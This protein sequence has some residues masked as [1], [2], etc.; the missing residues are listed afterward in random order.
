VA[1][2]N[3][4]SFFANTSLERR[5]EV[6]K[7][8]H[9]AVLLISL[10]LSVTSALGRELESLK[11]GAEVQNKFQPGTTYQVQEVT[12]RG[13][14]VVIP[15]KGGMKGALSGGKSPLGTTRVFLE[16]DEI[17][18]VRP[19]APLTPED[20]NGEDGFRRLQEVL[21]DD[22]S[23]ID[24]AVDK[25]AKE[26]TEQLRDR[27]ALLRGVL[28]KTKDAGLRKFLEK[29]L[30]E[31]AQAHGYLRRALET[32]LW[33]QGKKDAVEATE[34]AWDL[35]LHALLDKG[36]H[37]KPDREALR[38][39]RGALENKV[40]DELDRRLGQDREGATADAKRLLETFGGRARNNHLELPEDMKRFL[41]DL[42]AVSEIGSDVVSA[43]PGPPGLQ[44]PA[45]QLGP[46][47]PPLSKAPALGDL[48]LELPS[49]EPGLKRPELPALPG[50]EDGPQAPN[51]FERDGP[52]DQETVAQIDTIFEDALK[53]EPENLQAELLEVEAE[54]LQQGPAEN[55]ELDPALIRVRTMLRD[56]N[57]HLQR[58]A[59][60]ALESDPVA[61]AAELYRRG[62][63]YER[64]LRQL[65]GNLRDGYR[66]ALA[67][68]GGL[69]KRAREAA[70]GKAKP[71]TPFEGA[72]Q[73]R[74]LR[75]KQAEAIAQGLNGLAKQLQLEEAEISRRIK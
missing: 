52:A 75:I 14:W 60:E 53:A 70:R 26:V 17:A 57:R 23:A 11:P 10:V 16:R 2:A 55:A 7:I 41:K 47:I 38:N 39:V 1:S 5:S 21:R 4:S 64:A 13:A 36:P 6:M 19:L 54:L 44:V 58:I 46:E 63:A 12:P 71:L 62:A 30:A 18:G 66:G 68:I 20:F 51:P 34:S 31:T 73:I 35:S 74:E 24:R 59:G 72:K 32:Q 65:P 49:L 33:E 43:T 40:I 8:P 45:R 56:A 48:P 3:A 61:F 37:G 50:A 29:H 15:N 28:E 25:D 9:A 22:R 69:L 27:E 42:E 67:Q